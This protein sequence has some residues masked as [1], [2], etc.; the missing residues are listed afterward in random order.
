MMS[1]CSPWRAAA[2]AAAFALISGCDDDSTEGDADAAVDLDGGSGGAASGD[3]GSGGSVD[4]GAGGRGGG[5]EPLPDAALDAGPA[6]G[7]EVRI[8]WSED[9][10]GLGTRGR[11]AD[12]EVPADWDAPDGLTMTVRLTH[13]PGTGSGDQHWLL[14][15]GPGQSGGSLTPGAGFFSG[16]AGGAD[17]YLLDFRGTGESAS[18]LDCGALD[19]YE[20][21]TRAQCVQT[22]ES[23]AGEL[24]PHYTVTGAARDLGEL[25]EATRAEGQRVLVNAGSFGTYWAHRYLQLYPDQADAVLLDSLCPP[26][27]CDYSRFQDAASND[28]ARAF[29]GLCSEDAACNDRLGGDPWAFVGALHEKV[30]TTDHCPEIGANPVALRQYINSVLMNAGARA[31]LPAVLYRFD[32]CT[33]ADIS[34]I[35]HFNARVFGPT[36]GDTGGWST[37]LRFHIVVSEL[38]PD[39][40]PTVAEMETLHDGLYSTFSE[41]V[42][43]AE[44]AETWPAGPRD[45]LI[46]GRADTEIPILM[47]NGTLDPATSPGVAE[48]FRSLFDGPHQHYVMLPHVT[49]GTLNSPCAQSLARAFFA[50]PT[51]DLDV[52]C[53]AALPAPDLSP[54]AMVAEQWLGVADAWD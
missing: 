50:E 17:V 41:S 47:L 35:Q 8:E 33:P 53:T 26:G 18:R 15:G 1:H 2:L 39:P 16:L 24:L 14:A 38:L 27:T 25:I 48:P 10:P 37:P 4:A 42:V 36:G 44:A 22:L 11:C 13:M 51:A 12:V 43:M 32:R 30:A 23:E 7:F 34:A 29:F 28:V 45:V 19:L 9:C 20:P 3:S 31:V 5:G 54:E 46:D 49:H 40:P 21:E 52:A 6:T